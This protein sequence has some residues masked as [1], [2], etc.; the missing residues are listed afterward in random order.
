MSARIGHITTMSTNPMAIGT[1]YE[2]LFGLNFDRTP[3]PTSYGE[4]LSDG[5]VMLTLHH[6]LPGH[7]LGLDHFGIEVDD[8]AA[9]LDRIKSVNPALGWVERPRNCPYPGVL[10]HDPG[11]NIFALY[12]KGSAGP[13]TGTAE[14]RPAPANFRRWNSRIDP[15]GRYVHHYAIRTRRLDECAAFYERVFAFRPMAGKAGD[16]NHYLSDGRV[17][18]MLIPWHIQDYA[19]ISVTGRGPDHIGFKVEDAAAMRQEI[20]TFSANFSPGQAPLWLLTTLNEKTRESQIRAAMI[21][22]SCPVS[23]YQFTDKDGT[24]VVIGDKTFAEA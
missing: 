7:R 11:G 12:Q 16:P 3:K 18:L 10:A 23:R 21:E 14:G 2:T 6:R 4:V 5:N 15:S 8:L 24:F 1:M 22:K 19:G 17:T 20:E 13:L 9:T